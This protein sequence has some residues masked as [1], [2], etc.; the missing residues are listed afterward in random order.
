MFA[1][2]LENVEALK[3]EVDNIIAVL[4]GKAKAI[5]DGEAGLRVVHLLEAATTSMQN[6]GRPVNVT[7]SLALA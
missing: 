3:T 7:T 2:R 5:V 4:R 6:Q 1:P